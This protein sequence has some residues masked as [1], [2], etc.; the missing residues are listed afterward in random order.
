MNEKRLTH[1]KLTASLANDPLSFDEAD[2][3]DI[4]YDLS[5]PRI[6]VKVHDR[7]HLCRISCFGDSASHLTDRVLLNVELGGHK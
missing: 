5:N 3:Q 4:A 6:E 7:F 2:P 1:L